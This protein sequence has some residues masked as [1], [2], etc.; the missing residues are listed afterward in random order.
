VSGTY[1]I[2]RKEKAAQLFVLNVPQPETN[3]AILGRGSRL[4][5]SEAVQRKSP[6]GNTSSLDKPKRGNGLLRYGSG[7]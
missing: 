2:A 1:A 4:F 5:Q 6:T 3:L 7:V